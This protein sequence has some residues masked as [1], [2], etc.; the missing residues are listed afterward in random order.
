MY[1]FNG[2]YL[3]YCDNVIDMSCDHVTLCMTYHSPPKG[4]RVTVEIF[5]FGFRVPF[6]E[7]NKV[8]GKDQTEKPNVQRCDELLKSNKREIH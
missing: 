4:V 7:V 5:P 3:T 2:N 6:G 8:R 1:F